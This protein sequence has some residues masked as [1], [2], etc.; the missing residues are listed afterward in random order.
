M[1]TLYEF[2]KSDCIK[3]PSDLKIYFGR[4]ITGKELLA[5]V[6]AA[7]VFLQS[8]GVKKG[9]VVVICLPNIPQ[10]AAAL[11]A[12]NK[13]GAIAYVLH[14]KTGADNLTREVK[15]TKAKAI[16]IFDRF[17]NR[18]KD[19]KEVVTVVCR[20][21][22]YLTFP[23]SLERLTE[24]L[25]LNA[26]P[27]KKIIKTDPTNFVAPETDGEDIAVYLNSGGTTGEPK[28]VMLSNRAFNELAFNVRTT[29]RTC[30]KYVE[31]M[32]MLMALPLFHGFGLGICVHLGLLVGYVVPVLR[33]NAACVLKTMKK[34]PV[35]IIVGVPGLLRRMAENRR[36]KGEFLK[37]IRLI[38]VGGDK[39]SEAVKEEFERK[40]SEKGCD[41]PI[42]E[43]YGLSETASVVTINTLYPDNGSIGQPIEGVKV[44]I[45]DNGVP[46]ADGKTGEI[47]VNTPSLMSGYLDGEE[48]EFYLKNGLKYLAT[49]DLGYKSG[50]SVYFVGRK[51][52]MIKIG[53]VNVF[54]SQIEETAEKF[55]G[56]KQAC[57]VRTLFK[58][59]P[60]VKLLIVTDRKVTEEY[61]RALGAFL[62][63]SIIKYA[64]PRIIERVDRIKTTAIGK[65]DYGYYER[66]CG[67]MPQS[68][69]APSAQ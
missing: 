26:Y 36:F 68:D 8:K 23:K 3:N 58:G 37:N 32:G 14:P 66:I 44:E 39:M 43:G 10:A 11:Y 59:K 31:G 45:F 12:V 20:A 9:D 40:L 60:A 65:A 27:Y 2:L 21:S 5:D 63:R 56:V 69:I 6:D 46:C 52:R 34:V 7:A 48:S 33:V 1:N 64:E 35:N 41:T 4:K 15:K 22:D 38:F 53:G 42:M 54:P 62:K 13:V 47:A 49:G 28:T 24:P 29:A 16:F 51:K 67:Q 25:F 50:E 55:N 17:A 57:A 18:F 19:R 30:K 61:K